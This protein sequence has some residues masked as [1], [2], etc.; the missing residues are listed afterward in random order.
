MQPLSR[1]LLVF[2]VPF[3]SGCCKI[4][5]DGLVVNT[6]SELCCRG[7]FKKLRGQVIYCFHLK[8]SVGFAFEAELLVV[9][10][11]LELAKA[12]HLNFIWIE[13]DSSYVV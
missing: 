8:D 10:W 6:P 12:K 7:I 1:L 2:W 5:T 3:P 11:A 13:D 9:I 4:N